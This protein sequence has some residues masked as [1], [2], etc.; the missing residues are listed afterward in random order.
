MII[1]ASCGQPP[2]CPIEQRKTEGK[3]E[4]SCGSGGG[5]REASVRRLGAFGQQGR[6]RFAVRA[7][8]K[9][10][11]VGIRE[12]K[13]LSAPTSLPDIAQ[14]PPTRRKNFHTARP[15]GF[16]HM[17]CCLPRSAG[18]P[19]QSVQQPLLNRADNLLSLSVPS[20][21]ETITIP[22]MHREIKL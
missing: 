2:S 14:P 8:F 22:K 21:E 9:Y 20:I 11:Q 13:G 17:S 6:T 3:V 5:R 16:I 4:R 10:F 7:R 12:R 15:S 1:R 18:T 19:R